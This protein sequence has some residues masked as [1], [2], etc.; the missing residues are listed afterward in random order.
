MSQFVPTDFDP[1]R[2][3]AAWVLFAPSWEMN[4]DFAEMHEHVLRSGKYLDRFGQGTSAAENPAQYAWRRQAA[5]AIDCCGELVDLRVGNLFRTRPIR[6]F[7]DSPWA[8]TI[9]RFLSDV[10]GAGTDMDSFM[11]Q[12]LRL[13]YVNG[14]DIVVDKTP[15]PPELEIRTRAQELQSGARPYLTALDPLARVDWSCNHAGRY[16]WV[17]YHLGQATSRDEASGPGPE[18]YL[19][20]TRDQWRLYR[21]DRS[22]ARPAV[23]RASGATALGVVPVVPLYYRTSTHRQYGPMPLSLMTRISPVARG[24]LNLLSQGQ[25]DIYMAIGILA[26]SGV[27]PDQLPREVAP[28]CWLGLPDGA[29]VQHI[30]PAV[31]HIREKRAWAQ[32]LMEAILRMGKLLGATGKLTGSANSGFQVQAERTDLDNEMSATAGQ[33]E[34]VER[35]VMALMI[36]RQEGRRIDPDRIGYSVAYN[37]KFVL[38]AVGDLLEQARTLLSIPAPAKIPE[39][40]RLFLQRVL[41]AVL[42]RDHPSYEKVRK[43]IESAEMHAET[44]TGQEVRS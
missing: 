27:E 43:A 33:L 16:H 14:V 30:T 28:M 7:S 13:H 26:A 25:L 36:S 17:R 19:T 11:R 3:H 18:Q 1:T 8:S 39:L 44:E 41:D 4:R 6:T 31:E 29:K 32:M 20:L 2:T 9:A 42:R 5:L 23:T 40:S 12:A 21:V 37:R 24:L 10:D 38:T 22:G 15:P 34:Q 35:E